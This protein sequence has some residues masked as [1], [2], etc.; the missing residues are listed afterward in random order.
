[1][2]PYLV[3]PVDA[4]RLANPTEGYKAPNDIE[5]ILEGR[6]HSARLQPGRDGPVGRNGRQLV[7]P[8]G[9]ILD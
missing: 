1:V 2:T 4:Q 7:G 3:R 9:F 6:V 8:V 5:R